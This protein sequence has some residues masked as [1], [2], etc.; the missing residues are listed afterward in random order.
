MMSQRF[1]FHTFTLSHIFV[2]SF[3]I[4]APLIRSS[5]RSGLCYIFLNLV[6]LSCMTQQLVTREQGGPYED[7]YLDLLVRFYAV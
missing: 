6:D 1:L 3:F 7:A 5:L 4:K 2:T